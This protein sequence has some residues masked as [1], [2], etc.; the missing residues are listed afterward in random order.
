MPRAKPF[1]CSLCSTTCVSKKAIQAHMRTS[2]HNNKIIPH[3]NTF[4]TKSN[5]E[6]NK[7]QDGIIFLINKRLGFNR[8]SIGRRR[9]HIDLFPEHIFVYLFKNE[10][11]FNYNPLQRKYQCYFE[12]VEGGQRLCL[13]LNYSNWDTK[14]HNNGRTRGYICLNNIDGQHKIKFL[15]RENKLQQNSREFLCGSLVGEFYVASGDFIE[16]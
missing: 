7:Y 12:G 3:Y 5:I 4:P 2:H 13:L 8:T 14:N 10:I 15:W 9:I 16:W 6:L 11:T 1:L